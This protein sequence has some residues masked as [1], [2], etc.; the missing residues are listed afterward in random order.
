MMSNITED[1]DELQKRINYLTD[2]LEQKL[3]DLKS[4]YSTELET[5]KVSYA[6]SIKSLHADFENSFNAI[7]RHHGQQMFDIEER[8][9]YLKELHNAQRLMM[10]SHLGYIRDLEKRTDP[11]TDYGAGNV[12]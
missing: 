7:Q 4:T 2:L 1:G 9:I 5:I 11:A 3:I 10:E 6:E 12:I 8:V